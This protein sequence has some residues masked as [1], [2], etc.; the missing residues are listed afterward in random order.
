M[1]DPLYL[2]GMVKISI[3]KKGIIEEFSHERRA[4]ESVDDR[5]PT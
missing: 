2:E 5:G 3:K 4:Y 1:R